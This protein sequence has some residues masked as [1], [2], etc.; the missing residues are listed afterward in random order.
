MRACPLDHSS[1]HRDLHMIVKKVID[2]LNND[3]RYAYTTSEKG[4]ALVFNFNYSRLGKPRESSLETEDPNQNA[5]ECGF[6]IDLSDKKYVA[7]DCW[8]IFFSMLWHIF[9]LFSWVFIEFDFIT[10]VKIGSRVR[11]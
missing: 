9:V 7:A 5:S 3:P 1:I 10:F 8:E 2:H 4:R 11:K 6:T